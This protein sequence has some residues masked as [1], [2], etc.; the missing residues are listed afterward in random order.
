MPL[1]VDF[2]G[3]VTSAWSNVI[4]FVPKLAAAL[5]IILVGYLLA[6][7]IASVLDKVLER[8]GFDRAVERGG[9]KRVRLFWSEPKALLMPAF[10]V[11]G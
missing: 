6:K 9:I 1:A 3:G 4:T 8:V 2:Q 5:V 10:E 11:A 7:V